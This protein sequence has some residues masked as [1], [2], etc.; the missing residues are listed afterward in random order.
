MKYLTTFI[1]NHHIHGHTYLKLKHTG[2]YFWVGRGEDWKPTLIL[3]THGCLLTNRSCHWR[4]M[5]LRPFG[6]SFHCTWGVRDHWFSTQK[7]P[8]HIHE[9]GHPPILLSTTRDGTIRLHSWTTSTGGT[10]QVCIPGYCYCGTTCLNSGHINEW[11]FPSVPWVHLRMGQ[12]AL[13]KI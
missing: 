5:V 2:L 7:L 6:M 11:D 8:D 13:S 3:A 10:L 1:W 4:H 12:I 9:W